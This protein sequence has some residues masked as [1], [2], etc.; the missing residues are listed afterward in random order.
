M[1]MFAI[2][3]LSDILGVKE[4]GSTLP[5]HV[6]EFAS[7]VA[8]VINRE[9]DI[10]D[11]LSRYS[12]AS[13]VL[14]G[15]LDHVDGGDN[16]LGEQ[17]VHIHLNFPLFTDTFTWDITNPDNQPETF[18]CEL[19]RDLGLEPAVDYSVAIAYEIRR[20]CQIFICQ[21]VQG[22]CNIQDNYVSQRYDPSASSMLY[23]QLNAAAGDRDGGE[24]HHVLL[25]D[26]SLGNRLEGEPKAPRAGEESDHLMV[27]KE[28]AFSSS[29][30][31]HLAQSI[32]DDKQL[33]L[34]TTN[35]PD[36][37]D[38]QQA[39]QVVRSPAH[40]SNCD[41]VMQYKDQD[42]KE[43]PRVHTKK[44]FVAAG[45]HFGLSE[46]IFNGQSL[47]YTL[48]QPKVPGQLQAAASLRK[49]KSQQYDHSAGDAA[50]FGGLGSFLNDPKGVPDCLK[51]CGVMQEHER[52]QSEFEDYT[53]LADMVIKNKQY[54][55]KTPKDAAK[56]QQE[57]ADK[58]VLAAAESLALK[59]N[60]SS[61]N[62]QALKEQDNSK[63][64]GVSEWPHQASSLTTHNDKI[65]SVQ[66]D[67]SHRLNR[68][69]DNPFQMYNTR[70]VEP[71]LVNPSEEEDGEQLNSATLKDNRNGAGAAV[72]APTTA[73]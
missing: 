21:K 53:F 29:S 11:H 17:L 5:Q 52:E 30:E 49:G 28:D 14:D 43:K 10:N 67:E 40:L 6:Q 36:S 13:I 7:F 48:G 61:S 50:D 4:L 34:K 16:A 54:W 44:S 38:K 26:Q 65:F 15:T 63:A 66:H 9:I 41:K 51:M 57:L 20:Q 68:A 39:E 64:H 23:H 24:Y 59:Q 72:G 1:K 3:F 62:L 27:M 55:P 8:Y 58:E 31:A 42:Q 12:M 60:M 19:V 37:N 46:M 70:D 25:Q 22:F 71:L 69:A 33:S 56:E 18:A 73:I 32:A 47:S 35:A 45:K 2:D